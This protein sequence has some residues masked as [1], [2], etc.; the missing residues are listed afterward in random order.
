MNLVAP[1][2]FYGAGNIGDEATLQGFA[3]LLSRLA[4]E[5]PGF[6]CIPRPARTQLVSNHHFDILR[7]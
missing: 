2:G 3:R 1:F 7:R 4:A 5:Y 6:G